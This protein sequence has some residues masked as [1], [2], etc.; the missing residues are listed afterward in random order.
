MK[1]VN[2]KIL[3]VNL[4]TGQFSTEEPSED[5]Y[6]LYLGGRGFIIQILLEEV[7]KG[8]DPLGPENK[9]IFALGPITGHPIIG[10]AR[11]S[12][13]A[14]SPLTGGFGESEVGGFW[15]AELKRSS[16]D[17]IIVEGVSEKP[18]YLWINDGNV[19]IRDATKIWG[20]DVAN[21]ENAI[22]KELGD[23]KIRTAIIGPAGEKLV[24]YA[25]ILNDINHA[26]GRTGMG[27]VMGSKKLKA[28]A[29]RGTKPPEMADKEKIIE[30]NRWMNQNFKNL[31]TEW[32]YGTGMNIAGYEANGNLPIRNFS[33]G[34]F[35]GVEKITP[36]VMLEKYDGKMEGCFGCPIK[37]KKIVKMDEPWKINPVYGGPEYETLAAFGS[38]CGIDNIEPIMKAHELCN[39]Y[40][41]DTISTGVSISF[42]MECF[43][44]G[45]LT[46]KDTDGLEL[47]F[48]NSQAMVEMVERIALRKGFGDL[49]AEG[50]KRAAEKIGKGSDGY[51][52]HTKGEEIPLHEP[53]LKQGMGLHYS[54]HVTGADHC[55]G[56]HDTALNKESVDWESIDVT[57]SI[58]S[59]EMSPQKA[60]MLYQV[61]LMRQAINYLGLCNLVPWKYKQM[62]YITEFITGLPMSYWKLMKAVERGITLARIFNIR[63]G[64]TAKDD[65][66]PNRFATFPSNGPLKGISIVPEKLAEAQKIY[67]QM[68]GWNELGIPTYARLVELKIEWASKYLEE[69]NSRTNKLGL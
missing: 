16:L 19:E 32:M 27:A 40:G 15:G 58:P 13:G 31:M 66:L 61:G 10:S 42:A 52:M 30:L 38:N 35:P 17:A 60:R 50:T 37:C 6:K 1:G 43:E 3:R 25:C 4:T 62:V 29:V 14:K 67:Y 57:E 49:L 20:L 28:I 5:Y 48:G 65:I 22:K 21:T 9:L 51:A 59:T 33:G 63:E 39:R 47:T 55:T 23:K 68:M 41:M 46:I 34:K 54:V 7:K 11:N 8:I 2:G 56:I 45:L 12:V 69:V 44:K 64:W 53:R 18:V 26:A 36:Q 24:R